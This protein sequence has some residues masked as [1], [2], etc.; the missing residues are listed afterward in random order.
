MVWEARLWLLQ[1]VPVEVIRA[2]PRVAKLQEEVEDCG[3]EL[4]GGFNVGK[5][6]CGKF[7][8]AG[9]RNLIGDETAV[10]GWRGEIVRASDDK[11]GDGDG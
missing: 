1:L 2:Q 4:G 11:S 7:E 9:T 10:C 3:A 5:V 6:G 8:K